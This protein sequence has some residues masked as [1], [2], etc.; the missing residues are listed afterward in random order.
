MTRSRNLT[1][2]E[3]F[4]LWGIVKVSPA[5]GIPLGIVT[6]EAE[7]VRPRVNTY[8]CISAT[9]EVTADLMRTSTVKYFATLP[10]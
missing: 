8:Q 7:G 9:A 6:R 1:L 4:G 10:T 2:R 3:R 5:C